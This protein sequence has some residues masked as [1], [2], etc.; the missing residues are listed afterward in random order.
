MSLL[1]GV[2]T[3][4]DFIGAKSRYVGEQAGLV[5]NVLTLSYLELRDLKLDEWLNQET[6]PRTK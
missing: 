4:R 2:N 6:T 3:A 1:T 5:S